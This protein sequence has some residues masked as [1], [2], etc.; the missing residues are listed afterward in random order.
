MNPTEPEIVKDTWAF[1]TESHQLLAWQDSLGVPFLSPNRKMMETMLAERDPCVQWPADVDGCKI[2]AVWIAATATYTA[3]L[4]A[5]TQAVLAL[6]G[7]NPKY[8]RD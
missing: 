8:P 6:V 2:L 3:I 7:A 4:D 5:E 1:S